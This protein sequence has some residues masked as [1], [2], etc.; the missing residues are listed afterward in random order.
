MLMTRTFF[1]RR[2]ELDVMRE[3]L[4]SNRRALYDAVVNEHRVSSTQILSQNTCETDI[5][6]IRR[7]PVIGQSS[8]RHAACSGRQCPLARRFTKSLIARVPSQLTLCKLPAVDPTTMRGTTR[9]LPCAPARDWPDQ[10]CGA[11]Q[12]EYWLYCQGHK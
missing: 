10:R 3:R 2:D 7:L 12:E 9:C 4:L 5:L 11:E 1:C 6:M 8:P